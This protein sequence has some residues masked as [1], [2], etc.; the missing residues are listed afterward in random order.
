MAEDPNSDWI[1]SELRRA[2]VNERAPVGLRLEIDAM[3]A[4]SA[5]RRRPPRWAMIPAA[6]VLAAIILAL[7]LILPGGTPG[8]P[9]VAQAA[10][11]S[12]QRFAYWTSQA[13]PPKAISPTA[14]QS[15][16][17]VYT[18][19]ARV[20]YP[21]ALGQW[22]YQ[23]ARDATLDGQRV[24]IVYYRHSGQGIAY[25]VTARPLLRDQKT[26]FTSPQVTGL[27][28]VSWQESGHSCLL[29]STQVARATL[30]RAAQ[31]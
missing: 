7:V 31:S 15:Q 13:T 27:T 8:G 17:I 10:T 11:L 12:A 26:G 4:R 20:R 23:S 3:S 6:G 24:L 21:T 16:G 19:F 14:E 28:V 2:A 22:T 29:V 5:R 25:V 30:L 1:T 9:T 18:G